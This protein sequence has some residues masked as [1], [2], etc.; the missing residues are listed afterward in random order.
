M[1]IIPN[2]RETASW[3]AGILA[4]VSLPLI[5]AWCPPVVHHALARGQTVSTYAPSNASPSPP[6]QNV[7]TVKC[8][9]LASKIIGRDVNYCVDLPVDYEPSAQHYPTLYFLHGLFENERSWEEKGGKEILDRLLETGQ[10]GKF[11][12]VMPDGR[13]TFYVNSEDGKERYEDFLI[14][15]FIPAIDQL[16]RTIPEREERGITGVSMGGYGSLHLSMRHADVFGSA[17][18]QSAALVPHLPDPLPTEGRWGFYMRI[19]AAPF[20][21]PLNR[22]YFEENNPLT[23]AENPSK[24]RDLQLYFDVGDHDRYGFKEG[25]VL[26]DQI[27]KQ[28]G[29]SHEFTIRPGDHGWSFLRD[30]MQ[31][32]LEF[33]W[34]LFQSGLARSSH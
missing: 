19:L 7:T 30:Y 25:N 5:A 33:H 8:S 17:S 16:Y 4:A 15:E 26:L 24:F 23:L 28:K 29:F 22:R 27:L 11:L 20:G 18:A 6:S 9:S 12:V 1:S 21:S 32:A 31:Y 10:L 14:Q 34:K 3:L 13:R 2:R